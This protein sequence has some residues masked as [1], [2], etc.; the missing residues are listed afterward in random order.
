MSVIRWGIL[1]CGDV[2]EVKS[3][4]AL[5]QAEGSALVA[6]MRRTRGLAEDYAR[7]HGVPRFYNR[8]ED[9]LADPSVDAVYVATPPGSHLELALAA[10]EA[11]KPAYVEKP[12]ARN[13]AECQRMIEAFEARSVPLFVAYYRR[14][15]PRFL[16]V[17]DLITTGRIG[18]IASVSYRY[19]RPRSLADGS[20]SRLTKRLALLDP[21][22]VPWRVVPEHAGGGMFL[23]VGC[24]ALDLL[25]FL[26]G[27]LRDVSGDALR[28]SPE[29]GDVEDV[30]TMR[31]RVGEGEGALGTALWNFAGHAR[32][33]WME[34]FGTEGRISFTVFGTEAIRL[35]EASGEETWGLP[36]PRHIQ[37]PLLQTVVDELRGRGKCPSTPRSAARTSAVMDEVLRKYYGGREDAFWEHPERFRR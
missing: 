13:F 29:A 32:E 3:G 26:L 34:I 4:P 2:T 31:F 37:G 36:N 8:A 21:S 15:L 14:A 12:M 17:K 24:H 11:G 5:Q 1:G 28:A 19:V 6:V 33:D 25:D 30:V 10:A 18:R 35:E 16:K 23:D 7:R 27:P 20:G 22:R 9:L